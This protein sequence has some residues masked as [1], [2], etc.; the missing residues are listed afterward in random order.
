M[1]TTEAPALTTGTGLRRTVGFSALL[2]IS[3]GS[4]IGSGWLLG[5]LTAAKSAGGASI[6]SWLLA[7]VIVVLLALVHAELGATYPVAG[8]TARYPRLAF[9]AI[10]GFTAGWVGWIQAVAI[11]PIEVEAAL[12][13]LDHILPGFVDARRQP[14]RHRPAHR[15]A[16]HG[17]VHRD[18]PARGGAARG[19]Q[20]DHGAVE[21]RDPGADGDR[22]D[23]R[24]VPRLATSPPAAGS[25]RSART[26][27]SRRCPSGVVFALQ[28]FEQAA[29]M[30]GE[31]RNPQKD[32][33]RALIGAVAM[34]V[35]IYL[36][37]EVAFVGA[38]DP[39]ALADRLGE[40]DRRGRLRPLRDDR[41]R[42]RPDLARRSCSTS[43]LH[44]A[45]RDRPDLRR[46]LGAAVLRPRPVRVRPAVAREDLRAR[47][48]VGLDA[49]R[50]RRR[51]DLLRALPE[52]AVAG[53]RWSPRR[54]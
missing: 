23:L 20:P 51:A 52:L 9:G 12:S 19:D 4:I 34:G 38:L 44:L 15:G 25:P 18:Q 37:L 14:H 53:L 50:P 36:A 46:H 45:R 11:A 10:A 47:H 33:P 7:G 27:C 32:L 41:R 40:P 5:A 54:R 48:P 26:A 31:A 29:Q 35:V 22:P 24:G 30:G 42:P 39:A 21:D 2:F 49:R 17:R 43:T 13:Y 1:S 3:L 28:G 16:A 8:G 6:L